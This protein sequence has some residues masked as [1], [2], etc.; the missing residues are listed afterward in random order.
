MPP[1][2]HLA[3][4]GHIRGRHKRTACGGGRGCW[5]AGRLAGDSPEPRAG[6][7]HQTLEGPP[8]TS[9]VLKQPLCNRQPQEC[10]ARSGR[11]EPRVVTHLPQDADCGSAQGRQ[12]TSV[13]RVATTRASCSGQRDSPAPGPRGEPAQLPVVALVGQGHFGS[14]EQDLPAGRR[15]GRRLRR[16][17]GSQG[18]PVGL[19]SPDKGRRRSQQAPAGVWRAA[20]VRCLPGNQAHRPPSTAPSQ[21]PHPT[22]SLLTPEGSAAGRA[23]KQ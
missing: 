3:K 22:V 16:T 14:D 11:S 12:D 21:R 6:T 5:R 7:R 9:F 23:Q 18:R 13:H 2:A 4:S 1:R 17:S 20:A 8:S 15:T 19:P 10:G